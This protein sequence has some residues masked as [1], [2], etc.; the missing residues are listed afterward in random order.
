MANDGADPDQISPDDKDWTWVLDSVCRE[1]GFDVRRFPRE[2]TGQMIR[3][4]AAQWQTL[5][6][7]DPEEIRRRPSPTKWSTLEYAGHVRDVFA[8]YLQRLQLMLTGDGPH[9]PDWDQDE[10]ALAARDNEEEPLTVSGDLVSNA[11][12]LADEFDTVSGDQ[13]S[14]TGFRGDGASFTVES[15]ARYLIH[16][17]IHHLWDVTA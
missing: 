15:L 1:C 4:N 5:L 6:E 10:T 3:T 14:R 7:G 12:A 8:V 2:E 17:P 13:W 11:N 9:Y 16:D